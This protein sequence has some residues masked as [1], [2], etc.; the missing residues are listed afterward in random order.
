MSHFLFQ[1]HFGQ[2][3]KNSEKNLKFKMSGTNKTPTEIMNS[4][5]KLKA[6]K[7]P[8]RLNRRDTDNILFYMTQ[9]LPMKVCTENHVLA[10]Y[11]FSAFLFICMQ[12]VV[13]M[14]CSETYQVKICLLNDFVVR[15]ILCTC[16]CTMLLSI[17]C[18][19]IILI[20]L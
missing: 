5:Y 11:F 9:C 4:T 20:H 3:A 19:S 8:E 14:H 10:M 13:S 16:L 7:F 6:P 2:P 18:N 15:K 1:R 12:Y 17:L